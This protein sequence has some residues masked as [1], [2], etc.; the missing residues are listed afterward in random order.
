MQY[1]LWDHETGNRSGVYSSEEAAL[2]DVA[3]YADEYG[4]A[5]A[6]TMGLLERSADGTRLI[7]EGVLLLTRARTQAGNGSTGVNDDGRR[8]SRPSRSA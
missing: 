8:R 4:D 5:V 7:A 3:K 6:S 1:E 2:C